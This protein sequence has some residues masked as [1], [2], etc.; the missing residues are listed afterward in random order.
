MFQG[1]SPLLKEMTQFFGPEDIFVNTDI[2]L[3]GWTDW[4]VEFG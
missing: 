3:Y 2:I 1:A 4:V